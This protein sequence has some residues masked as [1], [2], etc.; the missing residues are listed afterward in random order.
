MGAHVKIVARLVVPALIAAVACCNPGAAQQAPKAKNPAPAPAPAQAPATGQGA[1][2][3][4]AA[5]SPGWV[6]R[7]LSA[8]RDAP[9]ECLVEETAVVAKTG[10][11]V[12]QVD[13]RVAGD[14]HAPAAVLQLPL[15]L[16]LPA[17]A[18]LQVDDGRPLDM[19]IET[20]ENRGCYASAPVAPDLLVALRSGKQLKISFQNLG[21][22]TIT[23]PMP[24]TDFASAY[25]KIK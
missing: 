19:K 22:E 13:I 24:L 16:S 1:A 6:A 5:P 12:V 8:S 4:N 23:I 15:G 14:T 25:E 17:G 18:R 9:L 20:C 10:Q 7:C 11:L 3:A 2:P 21:K